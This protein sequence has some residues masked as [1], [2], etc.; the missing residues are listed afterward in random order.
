MM[1]YEDYQ[2]IWEEYTQKET[3]QTPLGLMV[4]RPTPEGS[5]IPWSAYSMLL[6]DG[7]H[8][9]EFVD[10]TGLG[11]GHGTLFL[12]TKQYGKTEICIAYDQPETEYE[13]EDEEEEDAGSEDCPIMSEPCPGDDPKMDSNKAI[14]E[15]GNRTMHGMGFKVARDRAVKAVQWFNGGRPATE[16]CPLTV[17]RNG[18]VCDTDRIPVAGA[19]RTYYSSL[20]L[21]AHLLGDAWGEAANK[22]TVWLESTYQCN[23][24]G[25]GGPIITH[26]RTV[27]LDGDVLTVSGY[28]FGS[29]AQRSDWREVT[30][31]LDVV[32]KAET[33]GRPAPEWYLDLMDKP[34]AADEWL[35][36][37]T[38]APTARQTYRQVTLED[39]A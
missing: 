31:S 19:G 12:N 36:P 9:G 17:M 35:G 24:G 7:P 22:M 20:E 15:R 4:G 16:V 10:I 6:E 21:E 23:N 38:T 8:K 32:E 18:D 11:G 13:D 28:S 29:E 1:S 27:Q 37:A 14:A 5:K 25:G 33:K 39:F 3:I 34:V 26:V 30:V 2:R